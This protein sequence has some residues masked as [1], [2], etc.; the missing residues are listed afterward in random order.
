MTAKGQNFELYQGD[1]RTLVVQVKDENEQVVSLSGYLV[2]WVMYVPTTGA[3]VLDKSVGN[4]IAIT[5]P[6]TGEISISLLPSDTENIVPRIY[7]HELEISIDP[8][9]SVF[10][11]AVGTANIL[12]SKA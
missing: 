5:S 10:T 12:S 7:N 9:S 8:A 2:H 3:I 11:V 4:G 6:T 1:T